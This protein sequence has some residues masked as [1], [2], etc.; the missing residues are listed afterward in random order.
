M[1]FQG[2]GQKAV[3]VTPNDSVDISLAPCIGL[4]VGGAGN[5]VVTM[6]DGNDVT[7]TGVPAGWWMPISVTRVKSTGTT[8]T[9][10]VAVSN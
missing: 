5:L 10:I 7:F 9:N 2:I 3:A 8:A 6:S 4:F 1:Q